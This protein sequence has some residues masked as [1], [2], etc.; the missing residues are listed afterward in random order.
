M[1]ITLVRHGK[2]DISAHGLW[3]KSVEMQAWIDNYNAACICGVPDPVAIAECSRSRFIITSPLPRARASL[4]AL[5][6]EPNLIA[7]GL[8]EAELPNIRIPFIKLP[9]D[10]WLIIFRL[11]WYV[12]IST[13]VESRDA[14]VKRAKVIAQNLADYTREHGH[15]FS[16]GHGFMNRLVSRELELLGWQKS[17]S[18]GK[19]FWGVTTYIYRL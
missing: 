13:G 15:V 10:I 4:Q 7:N 2:P 6:T 16:M 19:G 17:R 11:Y 5:G 8:R 3:I 14:A 1:E 12:G 9:P 18:A